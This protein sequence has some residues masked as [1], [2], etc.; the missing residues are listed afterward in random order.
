MFSAVGS[1]CEH[2]SCF[3]K[4]KSNLFP[5]GSGRMISQPATTPYPSFL[6]QRTPCLSVVYKGAV[7]Q[8]TLKI[9]ITILPIAGRQYA[10][11][12]DEFVTL[13]SSGQDATSCRHY[14]ARLNFDLFVDDSHRV[15][16]SSG[17]ACPASAGRPDLRVAGPHQGIAAGGRQ[18]AAVGA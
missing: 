13:C 2:R 18:P 1:C 4:G 15:Q 5:V 7:T 8:T 11:T 10:V 14:I 3:L 12:S 6:F 16:T 17:S 9:W